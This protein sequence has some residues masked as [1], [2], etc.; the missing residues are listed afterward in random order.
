MKSWHVLIASIVAIGVTA[1]LLAMGSV[2]AMMNASIIG[3]GIWGL[4]H[5]AKRIRKNKSRNRHVDLGEG[6]T[7]TLVPKKNTAI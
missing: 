3:L 7:M 1:N 4:Y 5:L 2:V 6:K